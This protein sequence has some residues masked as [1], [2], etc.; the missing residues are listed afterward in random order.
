[1]VLGLS[2]RSLEKTLSLEK[3]FQ[4][5]PGPG[6]KNSRIFWAMGTKLHGLKPSISSH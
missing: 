1:M 6:T 2:Y 5:Q 3:P 4:F